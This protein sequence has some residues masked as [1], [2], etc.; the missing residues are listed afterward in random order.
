MGASCTCDSLRRV[1]FRRRRHVASQLTGRGWRL[2]TKGQGND[3]RLVDWATSQLVPAIQTWLFE[4]GRQIS[5]H[6]TPELNFFGTNFMTT[7]SRRSGTEDI[8]RRAEQRPQKDAPAADPASAQRF[9]PFSAVSFD[10]FDYG[11]AHHLPSY[12]GSFGAD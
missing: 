6:A 5:G 1:A 2:H 11:R 4:N 10:P 8:L 3:A 12:I 7:T 9:D